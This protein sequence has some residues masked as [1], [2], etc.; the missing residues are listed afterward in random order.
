M[1]KKKVVLIRDPY[2]KDYTNE[3]GT[4]T[5]VAITF[6]DAEGNEVKASS[7]LDSDPGWKEGTEVELDFF[8]SDKE[9][10]EGNPYINFKLVD[11]NTELPF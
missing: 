5:L 10:K 4:N 3:R 9:D 6:K 2:T 11:E 7:F 8:K 1:A